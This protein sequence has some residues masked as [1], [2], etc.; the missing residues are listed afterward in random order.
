M[1]LVSASLDILSITKLEQMQVPIGI[2]PGDG[3][4]KHPLLASRTRCN[5]LLKP[6]KFGNKVKSVIKSSSVIRSRIGVMS[7]QL[8]VSRKRL[9]LRLSDCLKKCCR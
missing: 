4:S 8:R 5:V 1:N 7:D 9:G 3:R 2:G 6:P